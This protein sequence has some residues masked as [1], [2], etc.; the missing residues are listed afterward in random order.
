VIRT[1]LSAATVSCLAL[2]SEAAS[3]FVVLDPGHFHAAL[4]F[5]SDCPGVEKDVYVF[6]PPGDD[7]EAHA[8][9]VRGF[10]S[11]SENP[12]TWNEIIYRDAD[13]LT[14]FREWAASDAVNPKSCL[15]IL[16]G[17]NNRKAEYCLAAVKAGF[18]VL[19]DKPMAITA[20]DFVR[21]R[22]AAKLAERKGL[23]FVDMMTGR[24]DVLASLQRALAADRDLYGEQER[25][26]PEDPALVES[27]VHHF[28]KLVDGKPLRRPG[29]YYDTR[30]QGEAIVDVTTH[31]VDG[32]QWKAFP[33]VQLSCSDVVLHSARSWTTPVT[34]ADYTE[35]TGL[36][37]WSSFLTDDVGPDNVLRCKANGEFT[38]ALRGVH[39]R[40][41]VLWNMRPAP[42]QG[43]AS[44]SLMRGARAELS[45]RK[46]AFAAGGVPGLFVL[47]RTD[48]Q[49]TERALQAALKRLSA[50]WPGIAAV[51]SGKAGEWRVDVP[52]SLVIPHEEQF[53][54]VVTEALD[55][56]KSGSMPKERRVNMLVKYHTLSEAWQKSREMK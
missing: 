48:A 18:N 28:C 10:N 54:R 7:V 16:A 43:D 6:A 34:L 15:V 41:S 39:A 50:V 20:D 49:A 44:S 56:M 24:Y 45:I 23:V 12:T 9:L 53:S 2:A 22:E 51:Q 52:S 42:G 3:R 19:S 32:L 1:V 35:S 46:G 55:W 27:S 4:A 25:G 17:R 33:D 37:A 29:W 36:A 26:T 47:A 38:Y 5:K 8:A 11:R 40:V 31:L 13:F 30:Q 14:R 21:L